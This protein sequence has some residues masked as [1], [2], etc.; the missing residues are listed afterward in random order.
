MAANDENL[1]EFEDLFDAGNPEDMDDFMS[2]LDSIDMGDS[3]FSQDTA[4]DKESS[5]QEIEKMEAEPEAEFD[6]SLLDAFQ[7][8]GEI[9]ASSVD[10]SG[11]AFADSQ[12][13]FVSREDEDILKILETDTINTGISGDDLS[14]ENVGELADIL[15]SLEEEG[16]EPDEVS[17]VAET[18]DTKEKKSKEKTP[19]KSFVQILI[20][21]FK[22]EPTPEELMLQEQ[23][24][25]EVLEWEAQEAE[26]KRVKKEEAQMKKAVKKSEA[27]KKKQQKNE[28]KAAKKAAQAEKK[29]A[30]KAEKER[31][32]GPIP[33]SQLIPVKPLVAFLA[34]AVAF[35]VLILVFTDYSHYRSSI[36]N[37]KEMFIHQN[38][39]EAYELL[40]GLDIKKK[41]EM[42]YEQVKTIRIVDREL[43]SYHSY[44]KVEDY[45]MALEAL[46]KGIGKYGIQAD[47]AKEL[48][49][50]KEMYALY[51]ELLK[52]ITVRFGM[53]EQAAKDLYELNDKEGYK[54]QIEQIAR[55]AALRDGIL[56]PVEITEI[57]EETAE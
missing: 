41:D 56:E 48:K 51:E 9:P 11:N 16:F 4:S 2:M 39:K 21:K 10:N 22:K 3:P 43:E 44:V 55:D 38:Y 12:E 27:D 47:Y 13:D 45:E 49:L 35:S 25:A 40:I 32:K 36:N 17:V 57:A 33:K 20:E 42:F 19:K 34:L 37:S 26:K 1:N 54:K 18:K 53:T 7:I 31:K 28:V 8:E 50:D 23:E 30:A 6:M 14:N 52:E 24:E 5:Q 29:A 15:A 46:V